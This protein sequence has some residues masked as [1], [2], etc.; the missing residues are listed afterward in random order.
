MADEA[1]RHNSPPIAQLIRNRPISGLTNC[2]SHTIT[3][4]ATIFTSL[5]WRRPAC[6]PCSI[7]WCCIPAWSSK[8][9]RRA[10]TSGAWRRPCAGT[11]PPGRM[12]PAAPRRAGTSRPRAGSN[13][14]LT[15][16]PL[17]STGRPGRGRG[18]GGRKNNK[19]WIEG[20]A[21]NLCR[22]Q[23][24]CV[25]LDI[26]CV[27]MC[28]CKTLLGKQ[29]GAVEE[30]QTLLFVLCDRVTSKVKGL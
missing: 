25:C 27:C 13:K 29:T 24:R 15:P 23:G 30:H 6:R 19:V 26:W 17:P 21:P 12:Y 2:P 9:P 3:G 1:V 28:V 7:P 20:Q 8:R 4:S 18:G 5:P 22:R 16:A 10:P 14:G 11:R